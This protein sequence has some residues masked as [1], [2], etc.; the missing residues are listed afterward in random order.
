H[1][2][3]SID[4]LP[5]KLSNPTR[6]FP[7]QQR[8]G[9]TPFSPRNRRM[10]AR[11]L[12]AVRTLLK[13]LFPLPAATRGKGV[14]DPTVPPGRKGSRGKRTGPVLAPSSKSAGCHLRISY[15]V[16]SRNDSCG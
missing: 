11:G 15:R 12:L 3:L 10:F 2:S 1:N 13:G 5:V 9:K 8:S 16:T 14:S 4:V 7:R 6:D